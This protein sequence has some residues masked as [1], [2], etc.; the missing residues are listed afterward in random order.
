MA[1]EEG[2][3]EAGLDQVEEEFS[4]WKRNTPFLYDLMISHPLEWPSL[5]LHWVPSTPIPYS[6]DSYFA[7]HKLIL[8]THTSGGAQDFLMVADVVIPTPDAEPGLGGRD[9]E[10]IV[11]KV[12]YSWR[13]LHFLRIFYKL[14]YVHTMCSTKVLALSEDGINNCLECSTKGLAFS[15]SKIFMNSAFI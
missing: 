15:L 2:K 4:I 1:A 11:P 9:Q 5:T 14:C 6:K 10:P 7:V 8:G 12:I 13:F 3:D